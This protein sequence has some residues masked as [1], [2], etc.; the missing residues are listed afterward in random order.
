M[1]LRGIFAFTLPFLLSAQETRIEKSALR[2][3]LAFLADDL[4]EGR[5]MGQRGGDLAVKYLETQLRV[6]GLRPANGDSYLQAVKLAS[7]L[8]RPEAS[9]IVFE[10]TK[11]PLDL[12]LGKDFFLAP[13]GPKAQVDLNATLVFVGHGISSS[14][15]GRDDYKGLDVRGK[16]LVMLMGERTDTNAAS[17]CGTPAHYQGR[18]TYKIEEGIRQGA[19]AVL[20][21][22]TPI[23][24][25]YAWSVACTGWSGERF[26]LDSGAA[27]SILGGII[28][29]DAARK[30]FAA[31]GQDLD[32]LTHR[33]EGPDFRPVDL[34]IRAKGAVLSKVKHVVQYNVV[35]VIPGMDSVLKDE[36]VGYSAH[37]DHFGRHED[38]RIFNGAVDNAS[39]LAAV[40]AIAQAAIRK[41]ARRSQLFLFLT[42]EEAGLLGATAY[43]R[44]PLRPLDK[45]AAVLNLESLNFLGETKDIAALGADSSELGDHAKKVAASMGLRFRGCAPDPAGLYFRADHFAFVRGGVPA[46]SPG[47]SLDGGWD[48]VNDP[49]TSQAKADAWLRN[50]YHQ[51]TDRYDP[52]W[53]LD[54]MAQQT[55]FVFE[56]GQVV[57]NAPQKPRWLNDAAN[58]EG[59]P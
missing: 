13:S 55:R 16:V 2:A 58:F 46:I 12:Q 6:L 29:Q 8:P 52:T 43:V 32:A 48:Y 18:W 42:G 30:L 24:A 22:H 5:G 21:V 51:P 28:S 47:F 9:R 20:I 44:S 4:L 3:H 41:P 45:T 31:A 26:A 38:G 49:K 53:N 34:Q 15:G 11:G 19:A 33:A 23:S 17:P 54:G 40:L 35:G 36:Y 7:M 27:T 25:R 56:L 14:N 57:A 50:G 10:T 1:K 59:R 37:W 39:G